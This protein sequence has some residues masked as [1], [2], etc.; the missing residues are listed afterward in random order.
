LIINYL[1]L[2]IVPFYILRLWRRY[3]Y[4]GYDYEENLEFEGY[5]AYIG[6]DVPVVIECEDKM[7]LL[8]QTNITRS[9][10]SISLDA[11]LKDIL[12]SFISYN[13]VGFQL[14]KYT[15]SQCSIAKV[16]EDLK[17]RFGLYSYFKEGILIVGFP[18]QTPSKTIPLAFRENIIESNVR[19]EDA[20]QTKIRVK[21][22]W[23]AKNGKQKSV[24]IGDKGGELHTLHFGS[25]I[26]SLKEL[27]KVATEKMKLLRYIGYRGDITTFGIP[28]LEHGDALELN[29]VDYL[30]QKGQ[31]LTN[32]LNTTF[33]QSGFRRN[34]E[35]GPSINIK[36]VIPLFETEE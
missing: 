2:H 33:G 14:G 4:L 3:C 34:I 32:A 25:E 30:Q 21:A 15:I 12:P 27:K 1:A 18:Y 13:A 36:D 10:R 24:S 35:I 17:D 9:Y 28:Y 20:G 19:F 23:I 26:H 11:M 7:W 16:L 5:I 31:Y 22:I 29:D 6:T 8:K